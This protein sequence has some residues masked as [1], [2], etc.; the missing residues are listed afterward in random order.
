MSFYQIIRR[1]LPTNKQFYPLFLQ[2]SENLIRMAQLLSEAVHTDDM[3]KREAL[4]ADI[5]KLENACDQITHQ[6][7]LKLG[8]RVVTRFHRE[9]IYSLINSLDDVADFIHDSSNRM[10][11]YKVEKMTAPIKEMSELILQATL[12]L[13]KAVQELE[14]LR[15]F[16]KITDA[17]VRINTVENKADDI[18]DRAVGQ[19]FE[20]E[21]DAIEIIKYKEVLASMET[22]TDRCEDVANVLESILVKNS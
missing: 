10:L 9:D 6:V 14:K 19:L 11:L 8:Q 5:E 4:Y 21:T 17:C 16:R 1:L 13:Y 15:N 18:F 22:A 2:M 20:Y 3:D 7:H 12:E